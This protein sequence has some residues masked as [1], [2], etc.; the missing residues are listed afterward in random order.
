M[1]NKSDSSYTRMIPEQI[2]RQEVLLPINHNHYN[3]RDK[4]K[5]MYSLFFCERAF[6]TN[7]PAKIRENPMLQIRPLWKTESP[8]FST[9]VRGC[10]YGLLINSVI[11]GLL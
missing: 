11:G 1:I 8:R 9:R 6:N 4:I 2:G 5:Q 10:C 3:F 7:Y